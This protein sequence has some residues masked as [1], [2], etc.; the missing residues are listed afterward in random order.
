M[1]D[2]AQLNDKLVSELKEIARQLS[3]PNYESLKKQELVY[4]I[5]DFQAANPEAAVVLPPK[6]KE[7]EKE[8]EVVK[9][10]EPAPAKAI[11]SSS[12]DDRPKQRKRIIPVKPPVEETLAAPAQ[13]E[14]PAEAEEAPAY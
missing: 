6:E 1:Y 14:V 5:L 8:K 12:S 9:T 13:Q 11:A 10:P 3:I 2:I 7:K 4:K